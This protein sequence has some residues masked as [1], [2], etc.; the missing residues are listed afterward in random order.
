M[1]PPEITALADGNIVS[2]QGIKIR[3]VPDFWGYLTFPVRFEDRVINFLAHVVVCE[4]FYGPQPSPRHQVRH[5]NGVKTDNRASN[6]RWATPREVAP[7]H[8]RPDYW[9]KGS[10][11]PT[12]KLREADVLAI[13][14]RYA[15]GDVRQDT[16]AA[17]YGVA[18]KT[19]SF[20]VNRKAWAHI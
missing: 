6:L 12:A 7:H 9:A 4:T 16:L 5:L 13:R 2:R 8:G 18:K 17:E 15:E 3:L 19:I 14:A 10:D 11:A 1:L 20:I